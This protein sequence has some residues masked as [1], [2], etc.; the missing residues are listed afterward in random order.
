MQQKYELEMTT[1][2]GKTYTEKYSFSYESQSVNDSKAIKKVLTEIA[3]LNLC[4]GE[5]YS[6]YRCESISRSEI[7]KL[8]ISSL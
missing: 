6:L 2:T 1:I 7:L 3:S 5:K 4:K 8:S